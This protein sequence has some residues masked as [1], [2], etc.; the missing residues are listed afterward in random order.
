MDSKQRLLSLP[1]IPAGPAREVANGIIDE[2][3]EQQPS[4]VEKTSVGDLE[5]R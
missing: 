4:R 3:K 5:R 1:R 2:P